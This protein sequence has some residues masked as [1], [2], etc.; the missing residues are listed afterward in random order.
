MGNILKGQIISKK[1]AVDYTIF[2]FLCLIIQKPL[3]K[4]EKVIKTEIELCT[5]A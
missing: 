2:V 1:S 3:T 4:K 5:Q